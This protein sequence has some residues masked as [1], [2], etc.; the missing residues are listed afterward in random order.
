MILI[1]VWDFL[2]VGSESSDIY[3]SNTDF[4]V[5]ATNPTPII[6]SIP[7]GSS[8]GV[9]FDNCKFTVAGGEFD[10]LFISA[11]GVF[12]DFENAK[13]IFK[14]GITEIADFSFTDAP[15]SHYEFPSTLLTIGDSAF[16]D[17]SY[18]KEIIL[19]LGIIDIGAFAFDNNYA[20][21]SIFVPNTLVS[22]G[23]FAFP[24][25]E[26]CHDLSYGRN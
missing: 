24:D 3:F 10:D 16:A 12:Y 23:E 21:N 7:Y 8:I 14:E 5:N 19:P 6:E 22:V 2:N 15:F 18:L 17:N 25:T 4:T 20:V 1:T 13:V 9:M 11:P 26:K